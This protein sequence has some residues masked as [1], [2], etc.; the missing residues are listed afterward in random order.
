MTDIEALTACRL[1]PLSARRDTAL[2]GLIH[3][4]VLGKGPRHFATFFR[5]DHVARGQ[6]GARH[7]LQLV[8]HSNGDASD[9]RF[10]GS[11][12][13][14]YVRNSMLGLVSVYNRLP[15]SVVESASSVSSF[16]AALQRILADQATAGVVNWEK[17][18]SPRVPW[19]KHPLFSGN[20]SGTQLVAQCIPQLERAVEPGSHP[21]SE[22][23][24]WVAA[25]RGWQPF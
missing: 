3:R 4:T 7:R 1:A 25:G 23:L 20:A 6:E 15:A 5:A 8:E 16:Q 13:A 24:H 12:P 19:H 21:L 11:R 10:P 22:A 2:L 17:S 14:D 18:F 9:Y